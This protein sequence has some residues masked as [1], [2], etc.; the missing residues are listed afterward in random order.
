MR[1][2]DRGQWSA[3]GRDAL[4]SLVRQSRRREQ[5]RK[6]ALCRARGEAVRARR[7]LTARLSAAEAAALSAAGET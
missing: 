2:Q 4:Q 6:Q 5:A 1:G 3:G 7:D